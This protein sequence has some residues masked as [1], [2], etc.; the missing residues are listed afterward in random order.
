MRPRECKKFWRRIFMRIA[1]VGGTGVIGRHTV[2][3]LQKAGHDPLVVARSRGIDV[4]TGDG[5]D[6]ALVGV[7]VVIDMINLQGPDAEATRN[8]FASA[9]QNLLAAEQRARVKHHVLLSIVGI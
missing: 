8:M 1:V 5:L 3:A 2:A 6:E 4:F 9:T 7:E